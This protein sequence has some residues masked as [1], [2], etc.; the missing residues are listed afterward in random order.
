MIR[1][2]MVAEPFRALRLGSALM[3]HYFNMQGAVRRF[4]L[5]VNADNTNAIEKYRHYGY[6]PDRLVDHVLANQMVRP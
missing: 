3:Q 4:V 2:W 1:Y 6:A 5:W